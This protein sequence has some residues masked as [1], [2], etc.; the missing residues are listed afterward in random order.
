MLKILFFSNNQK[1][2]IHHSFIIFFRFGMNSQN[3]Q[4][5]QSASK[6]Y[7]VVSSTPQDDPFYGCVEI[8]PDAYRDENG[9]HPMIIDHR[10]N[11]EGNKQ[12][13]NNTPATN[14][15][16]SGTSPKPTE[17]Q[18]N[19][20]TNTINPIING[21]N[22]NSTPE[23]QQDK[24]TNRIAICRVVSDEK[25]MMIMNYYMGNKGRVNIKDLAT[26]FSCEE[27]SIR[28]L[29]DKLNKGESII[30][31]EGILNE[32]AKNKSPKSRQTR[33]RSNKNNDVIDNYMNISFTMNYSSWNSSILQDARQFLQLKHSFYHPI[34]LHESSWSFQFTKE[35]ETQPQT[36]N[37]IS[38]EVITEFGPG[39]ILIVEKHCI[40]GMIV[41]DFFDSILL[42]NPEE[43]MVL[44]FDKITIWPK[45]EI[46]KTAQSLK[47]RVL[48]FN[49]ALFYGCYPIDSLYKEWKGRVQA[50]LSRLSSSFETIESVRRESFQMFTPW[51]CLDCMNDIIKWLSNILSNE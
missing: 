2:V 3:S 33:N 12:Q 47:N 30:R 44:L 11:S 16:V 49:P 6:S 43:K 27:D 31:P 17:N 50:S 5:S 26:I 9:S 28:E 22:S 18:Q 24:P 21:T 36:I 29:I 37:L 38:L 34:Y 32:R 39:P 46:M 13:D 8:I 7:S 23:K 4:K 25:R 42:K 35:G 41:R 51:R 45:E 15:V 19:N 48:I 14:P 40:P 10:P 1:T 20:N